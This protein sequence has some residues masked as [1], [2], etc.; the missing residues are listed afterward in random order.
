MLERATTMIDG[1][2]A[3]DDLTAVS[4]RISAPIMLSELPRFC[5]ILTLASNKISNIRKTKNISS[6]GV[7]GTLLEPDKIVTKKL[8]YPCTNLQWASEW[9]VT[10]AEKEQK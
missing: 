9:K 10:G 1:A 2:E 3:S 7:K 6:A 4:P 8:L 5:G